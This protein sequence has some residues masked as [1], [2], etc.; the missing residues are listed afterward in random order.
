[1]APDVV[2]VVFV[3]SVEGVYH[4]VSSSLLELSD[5]G[6]GVV[7]SLSEELGVC[8]LSDGRLSLLNSWMSGHSILR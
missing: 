3:V 2:G 4:C 6:L 8:S 7:G 5:W 1:M